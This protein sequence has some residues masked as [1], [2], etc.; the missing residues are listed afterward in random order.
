[1]KGCEEQKYPEPS[2]SESR[3][4]VQVRQGTPGER[5]AWSRRPKGFLPGRHGRGEPVIA[6]GDAAQG[7]KS[8]VR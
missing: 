2:F 8:P 1:M 5:T 3:V 7:A 6:P 4:K